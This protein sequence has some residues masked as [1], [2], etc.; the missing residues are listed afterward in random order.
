MK[1][2]LFNEEFYTKRDWHTGKIILAR[3][4]QVKGLDNGIGNQ[5]IIRRNLARASSELYNNP[6]ARAP[7][8]VN[9]VRM[10]MLDLM[11]GEKLAGQTAQGKEHKEA[12][13]AARHARTLKL[14]SGATAESF[15]YA[16]GPTGFSEYGGL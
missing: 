8:S 9:G 10:I 12:R 16:M 1:G 7:V 4:G 3:N 5:R 14:L 6:A 2:H 11:V 13:R 15:R